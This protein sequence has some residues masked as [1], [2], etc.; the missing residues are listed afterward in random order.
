[1]RFSFDFAYINWLISA[2]SAF[3]WLVR[4]V[5]VLME[6]RLKTE[7]S[8]LTALTGNT[9]TVLSYLHW[10]MYVFHKSLHNKMVNTGF[11]LCPCLQNLNTC[12]STS[13]TACHP[14]H[15][16]LQ[17]QLSSSGKELQL[18]VLQYNRLKF[19]FALSQWFPTLYVSRTPWASHWYS[20]ALPP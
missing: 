10:I 13:F 7:T 9:I 6:R 2:V 17:I 8:E 18:Q 20:Q 4:L 3:R 14:L 16:P 12:C 15:P 11:V 19:M 5:L 1:M